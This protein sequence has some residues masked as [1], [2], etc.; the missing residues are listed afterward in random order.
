MDDAMNRIVMLRVVDVMSKKVVW[1]S[2]NHRMVDVAG[3]LRKFEMSSAPVVDESGRVIGVISASD[4]LRRDASA[5]GGTA[6]KDDDAVRSFMS[7]EIRTVGSHA[8]LLQAGKIMCLHHVHRLPVVDENGRV[9]GVV[10]TMD[11]VAAL[12]NVVEEKERG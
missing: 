3:T 9:L 6:A 11:I 2:P 8:T 4:F 12:M 7:T 10:S 1:V 5:G